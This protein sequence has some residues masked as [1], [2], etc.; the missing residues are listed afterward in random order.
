MSEELEWLQSE[1]PEF[2]KMQKNKTH[3]FLRAAFPKMHWEPT[4]NPP[5]GWNEV[6]HQNDN[7]VP[8]SDESV[9]LP[10]TAEQEAELEGA[11]DIQRKKLKE[12]FWNNA[13]SKTTPGNTSM[14]KAFA[15][16]LGQC[17]RGICDLK[18]IE[19]YS[20]TY[21]KMK[22]QPLVD[23]NIQENQLNAKNQI[24]I[25]QKHV[26]NC[27]EAEPEEVKAEIREEAAKINA[28]RR[29]GSIISDTRTKEEIYRIFFFLA[30]N[31]LFIDVNY[32]M[33][34][35][36]QE[37]LMVLGQICNDLGKLMGGWHFSLVMGGADPMCPGDIMTLSYHH[38]KNQDGHSFKAANLDFHEQYLV[39]FKK[40]LRHVF[41][42]TNRVSAKSPSSLPIPSPSPPQADTHHNPEE[43]SIPIPIE[44]PMVIPDPSPPAPPDFASLNTQ[45]DTRTPVPVESLLDPNFPVCDTDID[46][47]VATLHLLASDGPH[48]EWWQIRDTQMPMPPVINP[49]PAIIPTPPVIN[50][51]PPIAGS[52]IESPVQGQ[53]SSMVN[54][55]STPPCIRRPRLNAVPS[56]LSKSVDTGDSLPVMRISATPLPGS[57]TTNSHS[58][59]PVSSTPVE[60]VTPLPAFE[61]H[62]HLSQ[63]PCFL[64]QVFL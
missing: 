26:H 56:S 52:P 45:N 38:S 16:L 46:A 31:V 25:M 9:L 21:Y 8:D 34:R 35:A 2:L 24:A 48:G 40:Y 1:L 59:L 36:I 44:S 10:L 39:P 64:Q 50:T 5:H 23:G 12:W 32:L 53:N 22:V 62:L 41:H 37:L 60:N 28:S 27:F 42:C 47:F 7:S 55:S 29:L 57:V 33:Y 51:P 58:V 18:D 3:P 13:K 19:V 4:G 54:V 61:L 14:S 63:T 11:S 6:D 43:P 49:P 15:Q 17:A 30:A 20:R